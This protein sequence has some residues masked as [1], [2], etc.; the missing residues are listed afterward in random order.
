MPGKDI[1]LG[2]SPSSPRDLLF[3]AREDDILLLIDVMIDLDRAR[4]LSP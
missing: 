4:A 1:S 3:D 2:I